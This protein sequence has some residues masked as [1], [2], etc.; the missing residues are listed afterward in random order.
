MLQ[1]ILALSAHQSWSKWRVTY[2]ALVLLSRVCVV[3]CPIRYAS[4]NTVPKPE[5]IE[6]TAH[7]EIDKKVEEEMEEVKVR[8]RKRFCHTCKDGQAYYFWHLSK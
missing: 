4:D 2:V 3:P 6:E 7:E 8:V 1:R 5:R